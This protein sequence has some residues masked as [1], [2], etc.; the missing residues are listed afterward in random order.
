MTDNEF[1]VW[2]KS[3]SAIRCVLVE[4]AV[5]S[6]GAETVRYMSNINYITAPTDVPANVAYLPVIGGGATI[7]ER[8]SI[9]GAAALSYGDIE[10]DNT[11]GALDS[12]LKDIWVNRP[13]TVFMGDVRWPR[14]DFR[15]IFSGAT[16]GI[17]SRERNTLNLALRDKLQRLNTPVT[18]VRLAGA[19]QNKDRIRPLCFGECHNVEPLLVEAQ[20]LRYQLHNGPIERIIEVRD[21]GV[22]VNFLPE[23]A[24][25][26]FTLTAQPAGVITVSVQGDAIGGAYINTIGAIVQ[27]ILTGYGKA[28]DRFTAA[29]L[30]TAAMT[31]FAAAHPQ[32]VGLYL[33]DRTNVLQACADLASS[34]GAQL[35]MG[36]DGK[37]SLLK[38][39]LP[40]PGANT[41][42]T[43]EQMELQ[44]LKMIQQIPVQAAVKIGYCKNWTVQT[45]L[46]TG[47]PEAHKN[48]FAMEWLTTSATSPT[49]AD[50]YRL[51]SEPVQADTLLLTE[52]AGQDEAARRLALWSTQRAVAQY[53]GTPELLLT[54]LG[55]SHTIK[56]SRFGLA[57]GVSGQVLSITRDWLAGRVNLEVLL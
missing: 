35:V 33:A 56:H 55:S 54:R 18:D 22:P 17:D 32:A 27:R 1:I 34:V 26:S 23:L 53:I 36:A 40:A 20:F 15:Q 24:T 49:A 29:D 37:L 5:Q 57:G 8:L 48:L 3:P 41:A 4:A 9:D 7:T 12:W 6:G 14:A 30:D 10:I 38:I 31:A 51:T 28:A 47:I 46:Q 16:A 43:G 44:S 13:I 42:V 11:T 39:A 19:T 52:V 21:N 2:L 45:N 25:G 50:I